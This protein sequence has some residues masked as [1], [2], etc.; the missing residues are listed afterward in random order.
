MAFSRKLL[1]QRGEEIAANFLRK[2]GFR[3]LAQN[4]KTRLGEIDI[5]ALKEKRKFFFFK[6]QTVHFI[7][8]KSIRENL[9]F[10][11]ELKVN[12]KKKKKI[13]QVAEIWLSQNKKFKNSPVQVDVLSIVFNRDLKVKEI[14][15][16]ENIEP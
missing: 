9:Y 10:F 13:A 6:Q 12:N 16:F 2:K 15:F 14:A 7:E 8:V 3:I 1:G 4:F 11:P 5:I